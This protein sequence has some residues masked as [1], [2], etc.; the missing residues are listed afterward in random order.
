ML[1]RD[2]VDILAKAL[3]D[4]ARNHHWQKMNGLAGS[5]ELHLG[6]HWRH[7]PSISCT[8]VFNALCEARVF[9]PKDL[10]TRERIQKTMLERLHHDNG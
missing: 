8:L 9:K 1:P 10:D 7:C 4:S 2:K 3:K 5:Q 6:Q